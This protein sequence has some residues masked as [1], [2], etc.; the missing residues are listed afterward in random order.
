MFLDKSIIISDEFNKKIS[1]QHQTY[2]TI[3]KYRDIFN[4]NFDDKLI[5][6]TIVRNPYTRII[7][8]LFHLKLIKSDSLKEEVFTIINKYIVTIPHIHDNHNI[9]Q[10]KYI[11]DSDENIIKNI[12]IL[13]IETLK[14]DMIKI[15]FNDFNIYLNEDSIK[16][17]NNFY[18]KDF[19]L[20]NYPMKSI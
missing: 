5:I 14:D 8:D 17:I 3:Y 19:T 4:V 1:L 12:K 7:S 6:F 9:P 18:E 16:L 20:F 2:N 11:I 13:R 10:Y 15:G